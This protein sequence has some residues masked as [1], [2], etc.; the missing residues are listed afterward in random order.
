MRLRE[1]LRAEAGF[2]LIELSIAMLMLNVGILAIVAAF[3]SG[4]VALGRASLV[5]N[6]TTLADTQMERYR[7]LR[8]CQ[9]YAMA[10]QMPAG[11]SVYALDTSAY[12]PAGAYYSSGT[13]AAS[14]NWV[15]DTNDTTWA[16]AHSPVPASTACTGTGSNPHQ[17][18]TGADNRTYTVDSYFFL[19]QVTSGG[20]EKQV[21]IIVRDP[22][23]ASGSLVR[24]SST[25]DPFDQ[26]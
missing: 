17:S 5:A 8:N 20:W 13:A 22:S 3:N 24:E 16:N 18:L 19:I 2:G 1:R 21:T 9:I 7:G 4:A 25:F 26:P 12:S 11:T 10:S 14:Q 15:L 6:A 23:N